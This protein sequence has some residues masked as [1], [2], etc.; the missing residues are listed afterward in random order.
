MTYTSKLKNPLWQRKRLEVLQRDDFA[1]TLCGDKMNELHIH[2]LKYTG[3]PWEAPNEDMRT[4]CNA[5]HKL[6]E[7]L[8]EEF[9][10]TAVLKR[11][12]PEWIEGKPAYHISGVSTDN[13]LILAVFFSVDESLT[14]VVKIYES[15]MGV[16]SNFYEKNKHIRS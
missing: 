2:H 7:I 8:K 5:C 12:L 11:Q 6:V 3:E 15:T 1:C 9:T 10:I 16:L 4:L 14:V 13:T